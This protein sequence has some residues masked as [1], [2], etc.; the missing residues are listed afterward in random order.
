[1]KYQVTSHTFKGSSSN[2][3]NDGT[4]Y[5][6]YTYEITF[7]KSLQHTGKF[8]GIED[9]LNAY[10]KKEKVT[11]LKESLS[12]MWWALKEFIKSRFI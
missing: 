9:G 10:D 8:K 11:N 5:E 2:T 3:L 4:V 1:M 7:N 6:S 12:D